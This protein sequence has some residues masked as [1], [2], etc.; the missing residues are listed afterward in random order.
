MSSFTLPAS[1][2]FLIAAPLRPLQ[3]QRFQPTGFPDVGPG[4]FKGPDNREYLAVESHQS[5]ANRL[6]SAC[7]NEE[8]NDLVAPLQGLPYVKVLDG[9]GTFLTASVL[10]AHRLNSVYVEKSTFFADLQK[11]IDFD[12][13]KPYSRDKLVRAIAKFDPSCLLHGVFLESIA[14]VLRL[15]RA[16]SG[17]IESEN[18]GRVQTGGV[19]NDRVQASSKDE[20]GGKTAAEG[21]GNVP[22]H[23][24][25]FVAEKTTA[26]FN[27]DLDQIRGYRLG[28][29]VN[30]LLFALVVFKVRKFLES[31]LRLRT[32]CDLEAVGEPVLRGGTLPSLAEAEA[33]L[34]GL[35]KKVASTGVFATPAV[36]VA[37]FSH[38]K[39][40]K[41]AAG[42]KK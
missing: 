16:L 2:R 20:E 31:G 37:T 40:A 39:P 28:D 6:E 24:T 26:Y 18:I 35:I 5:V 25:D 23:R 13:A 29:D 7:W 11:A 3:G 27:I 34:P 22:F 9:E 12:K 38:E 10:E 36:T 19:K 42:A 33:A 17:F 32:F 8:S 21:F 1:P 4:V 30:Q 41:K 14:G 15:P